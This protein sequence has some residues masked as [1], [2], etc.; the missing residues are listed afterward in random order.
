MLHRPATQPHTA[1]RPK[2]PPRA[3]PGPGAYDHVRKDRDSVG[4]HGQGGPRYSVGTSGRFG[5]AQ[6]ISKAHTSNGA[7][8]RAPGPKYD[9]REGVGVGARSRWEPNSFTF[10][11]PGGPRGLAKASHV[12]GPGEHHL[13]GE[14]FVTRNAAPSF[15]FGAALP[16]STVSKD[17]RRPGPKYGGWTA[18]PSP[19]SKRGSWS[20]AHR[21]AG[22]MF[23]NA[24]RPA[25]APARR[26]Q[27]I[28]IPNTESKAT[29]RLGQGSGSPAFSMAL[30]ESEG[31]R[32]HSRFLSKDHCRAQVG[33]QS[34]ADGPRAVH[35]DGKTIVTRAPEF[36]F[37]TAPRL[38]AT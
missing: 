17:E 28:E 20:R 11:K 7:S 13:S 5:E 35:D 37:G 26:H 27:R 2:V 29:P 6:F 19:S 32:K 31:V 38:T 33:R 30:P 18:P 12:P 8:G 21:D 15:S 3:T 10:G 14:R 23:G 22:S 36:A 24:A 25:S 4:R 16:G 1:R 9:T 34:P